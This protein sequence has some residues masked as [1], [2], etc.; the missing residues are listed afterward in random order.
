MFSFS[1]DFDIRNRWIKFV[2]RKDW[3]P[4]SSSVVCSKHFEDKYL[5]KG[6]QGKRFR[7]KKKLKPIPTIYL[8]HH[9]PQLHYQVQLTPWD[10]LC[11]HQ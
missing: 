6:E 11:H 10:I 5:K 7:L 1:I 9:K 3:E 8:L 4:S 2:N